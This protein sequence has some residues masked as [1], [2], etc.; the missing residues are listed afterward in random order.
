MSRDLAMPNYHGGCVYADAILRYLYENNCTI[1]YCW[2]TNWENSFRPLFRCP[3]K[4]AYA[5]KFLAFESFVIGKYVIRRKL[6]S[7]F[8]IPFYILKKIFGSKSKRHSTKDDLKKIGTSSEKHYFEQIVKRENPDVVIVDSPQIAD[9]LSYSFDRG[10]ENTLKIILTTDIVHKR[11]AAYEQSNSPLDFIP[12]SREEEIRL[13]DLSDVVIA[14]QENDAR[15]FIKMVPQCRVIVAPMPVEIE[16]N[17][18]NKQIEGRCFFVGGGSQHNLK[19][20]CWFLNS[21]WPQVLEK[22]PQASLVVC[23]TVSDFLDCDHPNLYLLGNIPNIN[24]YYEEAM[25]C[26]VPLQ[27]GTG[28]KIKLVEAMAKNRAV[29]STT[30]GVEGFKDLENGQVVEV[31][32]APD[33]FAQSTIRLLQDKSFRENCVTRQNH[34]IREHLLPEKTFNELLNVINSIKS[35]IEKK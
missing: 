32:D 21:V 31:A 8:S 28:F 33:E 6:L 35:E 4:P 19:G 14:I 25:V 3:W 22:L 15:D 2:L 34:W 16:P 17:D 29:I 26:I 30:I 18:S 20:I 23:G 24:K 5:E 7:I 27:F 13:I 11:V 10:P 9:I 1:I 12:L